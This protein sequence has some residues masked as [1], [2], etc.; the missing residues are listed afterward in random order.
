MLKLISV[1]SLALTC[2][3]QFPAPPRGVKV[4]EA[5]SGNAS[6]S[7]KKTTICETT[8]GVNAY[9][10]YVH[11]PSHTLLDSGFNQTDPINA[12]FWFF[13]SRKDPRNAPLTIV[14]LGGRKYNSQ[15]VPF[16]LT[17][18]SWCVFHVRPSCP[19][20]PMHCRIGFQLH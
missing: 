9:A 5:H 11:L 1:A 3:G 7:Y 15:K 4:V 8:P 10:G 20:W 2:L 17:L 13:E 12:F 6:I 16:I 18:L 14:Q 19:Q